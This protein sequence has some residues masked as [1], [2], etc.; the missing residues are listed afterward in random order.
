M[1]ETNGDLTIPILH[2]TFH[3]AT[4]SFLGQVVNE[5]L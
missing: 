2:D 1:Q 5:A 4:P 3:A